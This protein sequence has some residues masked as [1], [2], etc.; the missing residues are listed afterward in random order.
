MNVDLTVEELKSFE[1][2][3]AKEFNAGKILAPGSMTARDSTTVHAPIDTSGE[4]VASV[5]IDAVS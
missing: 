3:V 1:L 4:T 5:A 2:M